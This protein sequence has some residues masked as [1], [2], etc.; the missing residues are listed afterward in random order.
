MPDENVLLAERNLP[1][2]ET[3]III[4]IPVFGGQTLDLLY[5]HFF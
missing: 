4:N 3:K 2:V 5:F 1:R